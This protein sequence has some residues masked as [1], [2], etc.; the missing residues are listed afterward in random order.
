MTRL[1]V[2]LSNCSNLSY[3]Y[4]RMCGFGVKIPQSCTYAAVDTYP[5]ELE[6]SLCDNLKEFS[7]AWWWRW[8]GDTTLGKLVSAKNL[9]KINAAHSSF[10]GQ[11][12]KL[13][14]LTTNKTL[15]LDLSNTNTTD[16]KIDKDINFNIGTFDL[17]D[18]S[19]FKTLSGFEHIKYIEKLYLNNDKITS[20]KPLTGISSLIELKANNNKISSLEGVQNLVN[21]TTINVGSNSISDLYWLGKLV[22][23][24]QIKLTSLDLSDNSIENNITASIDADGDGEKENVYVDNIKIIEDLWKKGCKNIN[25]KNNGNLDSSR[26][27]KLTGVQY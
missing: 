11:I 10:S 14:D 5:C 15:S 4:L 13:A 25:L 27:S 8:G 1:G 23:N 18:C 24:N 9:E 21:L 6:L 12:T 17:N 26:L 20:L 22:E 16:F 2:D 3:I 7:M 19:Y